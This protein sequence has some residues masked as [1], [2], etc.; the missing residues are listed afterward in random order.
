VDINVKDPNGSTP[1]LHVAENKSGSDKVVEIV[2]LLIQN[3][4]NVNSL[5]CEGEN[6][7]LIM[8]DNHK[9][10]NSN[11]FVAMINLLIENRI[12]IPLPS[13]LHL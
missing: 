6:A 8:C 12:D 5:N 4:A 9:N 3:G 1:L 11:S 7:L 13:I 10:H 2:G